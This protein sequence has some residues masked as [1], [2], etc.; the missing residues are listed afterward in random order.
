M[1]I[2][3]IP[4][5]VAHALVVSFMKSILMSVLRDDLALA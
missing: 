4:A 3:R 1:D 5:M 2:P